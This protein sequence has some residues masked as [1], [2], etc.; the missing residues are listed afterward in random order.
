MHHL[1]LI[2]FVNFY[3][4]INMARVPNHRNNVKNK[5]AKKKSSKQVRDKKRAKFW[6]RA[7]LKNEK[8]REE[9][10]ELLNQNA[11]LRNELQVN[12]GNFQTRV[13]SLEVNNKT[14]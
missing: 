2:N 4:F 6:K 13:Q 3:F 5:L 9:R 10:Q 8:K 14:K 1:I 12:A 11:E 7:A